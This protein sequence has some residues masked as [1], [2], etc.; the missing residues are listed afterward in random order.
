MLGTLPWCFGFA[1]AG[2]ALGEGWERFHESSRYADYVFAAL[3]V[4]AVAYLVF[5]LY[6]RRTRGLPDR[7]S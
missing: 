3:L 1:G 7:A 6:R 5:R 4:G 2:L